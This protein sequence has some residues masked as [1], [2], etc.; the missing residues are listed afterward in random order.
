MGQFSGDA[1]GSI[2][3]FERGPVLVRLYPEG[4]REIGPS[5]VWGTLAGQPTDDSELAQALARTLIR[6]GQFAEEEVA[7]AYADWVDSNPFDVGGTIGTATRAMSA[8]RLRGRSLAAA[9][10]IS[11]NHAS[12]ANGALMRHSTLAIWGWRMAAEQLAAVVRADTTLT[13]PNQV[14][15][16][17]S[18][19][20]IT[21]L[22]AV[23]REGLSAREAY[24]AAIEW[25][26]AHGQ[27]PSITR[28]L[29]DA[30]TRLPDYGHSQGHV[31]VA[32]QNA[33]YQVLH[34]PSFEEGVVATVMSG[35]DTDTNAA[36]AGALL[37]AL[38]GVDAVPAQWREAVLSCRPDANTSDAQRP[39][40]E[41]YWPVDVL[42]LAD[43][44]LDVGAQE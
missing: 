28:V 42:D 39:R 35:G 31:L 23:I 36:I 44:L 13:H 21:A 7:A 15:I 26:H 3:E 16:D 6:T 30:R 25:D 37:G 10:R 20:F 17:A 29:A 12:E 32:L 8:A 19:A 18:S 14:C 40:P 24:A 38:Y 43:H 9:A 22:A 34:A 1:L 5:P 33:F 41:L 4:L 27:S 2:V 11:G